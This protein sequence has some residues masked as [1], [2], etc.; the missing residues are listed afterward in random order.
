MSLTLFFD[1]TLGRRVP[2]A[3]RL[4]GPRDIGYE[5]LHEWYHR[6]EE[7]P[8][9]IEDRRWLALVGERGWLALTQ[10]RRILT[11]RDE[12][13]TLEHANAG[14]V[15]LQPGDALNHELLE[16]VVCESDWLRRIHATTPRPFA[17]LVSLGDDLP[18]QPLP[19][20]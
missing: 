1:A 7:D 15:L 6:S 4:A 16:F 13:R 8:R 19:L 5:Y 12:R 18:T 14:V 17:Y 11:N 2:R 20:S 9:D 10:D 3:L